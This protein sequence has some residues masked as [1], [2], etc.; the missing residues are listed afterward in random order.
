M[1]M[2]RGF[3]YTWCRESFTAAFPDFD[4]TLPR[5]RSNYL[6]LLRLIDDQVK[7]FITFLDDEQ[8]R[9]N[10]IIIFLSDH[11]DF[12]GEYGLMRKGPELPEALSRIPLLFTGPGI[13]ANDKPHD[14]HVS[15]VDLFPTLCEAVGAAIP[16]GVQGKS[17]W[18]L[19]RGHPY[20]EAEFASAYAE[21]GFGGLYY[22]ANE[23]L[24]PSEDGR[25]DSI[26]GESWGKYDCLNSWTQCGQIRMVRQGD[27]KLQFDMQGNGQLY[28]L[29]EDPVELNN[30]FGQPEVAHIQQ[31]LMASLLTW[32]MRVQD[33]LPLPRTR[34]VMKTEPRNYWTVPDAES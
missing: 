7:R 3:K 31:T 24:K 30:L 16:D 11:G 15:I 27:W 21:S 2:T 20:P 34:Y 8:L 6:G 10:T 9:E 22:T 32:V 29:Q 19:L 4:E 26:D 5:A 18:P 33:P 23:A 14:A 28:H 1:R 17:L 13:Q 25:L 12:V